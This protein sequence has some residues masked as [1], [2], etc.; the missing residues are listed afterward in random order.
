MPDSSRNYGYIYLGGAEIDDT[1]DFIIQ[2]YWGELH[3]FFGYVTHG[4]YNGDG[5]DDFALRTGGLGIYV[6][7]IYLG[8]PWFNAMPD[9][10]L[11]DGTSYND[12]GSYLSSGDVNGDGYD[13]LLVSAVEYWFGGFQGRVYLYTRPEEWID[14]GAPVE[15][16]ELPHRPGWFKLDQNYPNP[17][18]ATTTIHFELGKAS[19]I[20]MNIYDL[21]GSKVKGLI[22][23]KELRPGGYNVSWAGIND[24]NQPVSS[25]IYLLELKVDQFKEIKKMVLLR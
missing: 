20:N 9:A 19:L 22:T 16:G 1:P 14:Y 10:S 12:F 17:F 13:E 23:G 24:Y 15:P 18:N 7:Y 8:S 5:I 2:D 4:D 6:V 3:S 11:I 21:R 25:G